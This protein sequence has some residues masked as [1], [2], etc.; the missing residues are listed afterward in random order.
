MGEQ[1]TGSITCKIRK[2]SK[3]TTISIHILFL[4]FLLLFIG[5]RKHA[6]EVK[7]DDWLRIAILG[8][9]NQSASDFSRNNYS[10][11]KMDLRYILKI[12]NLKTTEIDIL[13]DSFNFMVIFPE[14]R[15]AIAARIYAQDRIKRNSRD[16][17]E[18]FVPFNY[19]LSEQEYAEIASAAVSIKLTSKAIPS[20]EVSSHLESNLRPHRVFH[21]STLPS[22]VNDTLRNIY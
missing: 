15:N 20:G 9:S 18:V 8:V 6:E 13:R 21:P 7:T 10:S 4:V 17:L 2:E 22:S 16:T 12:D 5:C 19:R 14:G 3:H 1:M 11:S